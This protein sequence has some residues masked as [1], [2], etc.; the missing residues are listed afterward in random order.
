MLPY[1]SDSGGAEQ[2]DSAEKEQ[3]LVF[4]IQFP[5]DSGNIFL[6]HKLVDVVRAVENGVD[7]IPFA[8]LLFQHIVQRIREKE[9]I[10]RRTVIKRNIVTAAAE[11][12][13]AFPT[14]SVSIQFVPPSDHIFKIP[15]CSGRILQSCKGF[16]LQL[17]F[18]LLALW[19]FLVGIVF[20]GM[21]LGVGKNSMVKRVEAVKPELEHYVGLVQQIKAKSKER[22]HLLAEKKEAP[23]YQIPKLLDLTRRIA[24]LTEEIEELKT[25]KEMLLRS[26]DCAG[27]WAFLM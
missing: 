15:L 26:L 8:D 22:R 17:P 10:D 25:E 19:F 13:I 1:F 14:L 2:S 4:L 5:E 7:Q 12:V 3:F 18:E 24:G 23:F 11:F 20:K 6:R 9:F 16:Y 27:D 21:F